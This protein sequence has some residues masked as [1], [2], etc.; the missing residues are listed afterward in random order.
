MSEV[1]YGNRWSLL[2]IL[3]RSFL[4]LHSHLCSLQIIPH[5]GCFTVVKL[6]SG[7]CHSNKCSFYNLISLEEALDDIIA[8]GSTSTQ[9]VLTRLNK[10]EIVES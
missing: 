9:T 2:S 1:N 8:R 10:D 4:N 5:P 6:G 7:K 3:V